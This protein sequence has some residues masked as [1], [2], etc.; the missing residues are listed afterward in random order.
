MCGKGKAVAAWG[1]W[2]F[3][4]KRLNGGS[5]FLLRGNRKKTKRSGEGLFDGVEKLFAGLERGRA[6]G[7]DGGVG[8]AVDV[9]DG[10]LVVAFDGEGAETTEVDVVALGHVVLD[11]VEEGV[12]DGDAGLFANPCAGV[13]LFDNIGFSH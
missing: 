9:V 13:D 8:A 3:L 6:V 10:F 2:P 5:H 1:F 11:G 4:I 12:D 7:G